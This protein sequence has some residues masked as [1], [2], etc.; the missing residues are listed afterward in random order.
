MNESGSCANYRIFKT[1]LNFVKYINL[2]QRD[3]ISLCKFKLPITT[4][5]YQRTKIHD[6]ICTICKNSQIGDE[7]HYLFECSTL[8]VERH[9]Y[10]KPYYRVRGN[11]FQMNTLMN[12]D[13][14][15]E[16]SNLA[17]FCHCIMKKN[18]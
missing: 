9:L 3:R 15:S 14:S 17:K 6:R 2:N 12:S 5:R 18:E 10:L 1:N 16:M 13:N 8:D 4:G 7:F 11:T